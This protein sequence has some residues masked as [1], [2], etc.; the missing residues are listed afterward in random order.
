[1]GCGRRWAGLCS[2]CGSQSPVKSRVCVPRGS[3]NML[4][5]K[6]ERLGSALAFPLKACQAG[7]TTALPRH[8][9]QVLSKAWSCFVFL[10]KTEIRYTNKNVRW[11][12]PSHQE[13]VLGLVG[14]LPHVLPSAC[15]DPCPPGTSRTPCAQSLAGDTALY[16]TH[17]ASLPQTD[18]NISVFQ[19]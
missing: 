10:F 11:M 3:G 14:H 6:M 4:L 9:E 1:M 12:V 17:I 2:M 19:N 13:V 5:E 7:L 8:T 18:R 15:Q 16:G